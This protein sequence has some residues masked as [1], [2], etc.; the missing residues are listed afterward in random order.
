MILLITDS[1]QPIK[2]LPFKELLYKQELLKRRGICL[3]PNWKGL[4]HMPGL[5]LI[6]NEQHKTIYITD[7]PLSRLLNQTCILK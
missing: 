4:E 1:L 6:K 3:L 5:F 2:L 7:I